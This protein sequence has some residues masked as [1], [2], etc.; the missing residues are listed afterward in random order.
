M[1]VIQEICETFRQHMVAAF[2]VE[3]DE[4]HLTRLSNGFPAAQFQNALGL[5]QESLAEEVAH[6]GRG[7]SREAE[8]AAVAGD[9]PL[10]WSVPKTAGEVSVI[11]TCH[12]YGRFLAECLESIL[13]QTLPAAEVLVVLDHCTDESSVIADKFRGRG[14]RAV[15]HD[16]CDVYLSRRLGLKLTVQPYVIFFDADDKMASDYVEKLM[17]VMRRRETEGMKLGVVT[18]YVT[19]FGHTPYPEGD[20]RNSW[21]PDP[22]APELDIDKQNFA[23]GNS[24]VRREALESL[25]GTGLED[26]SL[27]NRIGQDW[28][29]WKKLRRAGW[30]F[31]RADALVQY[32]RHTKNSTLNAEGPWGDAMRSALPAVPRTHRPRALFLTPHLNCGGVSAHFKMLVRHQKNVEWIGTVLAEESSSDNG[33]VAWVQNHMPVLG[34]I[35]KSS[36]FP[37]HAN[38]VDRRESA[39]AALDSLIDQVDVVY[40][41]GDI[42]SLLQHVRSKNRKIGAVFGVH[43]T[44]QYT[45]RF[46][47]M[48]APFVDRFICI[49]E[50]AS[51]LV[52]PERESDGRIVLGGVDLTRLGQSLMNRDCLRRV[53]GMGQSD[54]AVGYAGRWS[55]EKNPHM[56]PAAV[57]ELR[58]RL[59]TKN[60][61]FVACSPQSRPDTQ[62]TPHAVPQQQRLNAESQASP[63]IW[64]FADEETPW[65]LG[66][67]YKALD[68]LV[69]PSR[70]EGGPL[71]MLEAL[72]CR[73]P[74]VMTPVGFGPEMDR[75]HSDIAVFVPLNPSPQQ[76]ADGIQEALGPAHQSRLSSNQD[77]VLSNSSS[78]MMTSAWENAME[79]A[80]QERRGRRSGSQ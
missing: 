7:P 28:E 30:E 39:V 11:V 68:V 56:I 50:A 3:D 45:K 80:V 38:N 21:K 69:I 19:L 2:H 25:G 64:T 47:D 22:N 62:G 53:W 77:Y 40:G 24:L 63:V 70:N 65:T 59:G 14:V 10:L 6:Q 60:I 71:V 37:V 54:I 42:S 13:A 1:S 20:P 72:A 15:Q 48:S 33:S 29:T 27:C 36:R 46:L 51:L 34:S 55:G 66:D 74:V 26:F 35:N 73:C 31:D 5:L 49:C 23:I 67:V 76:L 52:E 9:R 16:A 17:A 61:R 57:G 32:R 58:K 4:L 12:D 44:D 18:G 8:V 79:E 41:W 78:R 43:G 75:R